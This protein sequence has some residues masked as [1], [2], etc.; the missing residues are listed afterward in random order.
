MPACTFIYLCKVHMLPEK[1][2]TNKIRERMKSK[3]NKTQT[4]MEWNWRKNEER[5][6]AKDL[7]AIKAFSQLQNVRSHSNEAAKGV[8][9]VVV[10]V[11]WMM[12]AMLHV[13]MQL[14]RRRRQR[15]KQQRQTWNGKITF[16]VS[17]SPCLSL[18]YVSDRSTICNV[19]GRILFCFISPHIRKCFAC[20]CI[21]HWAGWWLVC[22]YPKAT[23]LRHNHVRYACD[24]SAALVHS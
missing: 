2:E 22:V 18:C 11:G 8:A 13:C 7:A 24:R 12:L 3:W 9:V 19:C 17:L 20:C 23:S 21:L 14:Q 10:V 15:L 5:K 16:S 1:R 6:I 4:Q